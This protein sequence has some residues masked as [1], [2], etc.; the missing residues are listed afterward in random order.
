MG[1]IRTICETLLPSNNSNAHGKNDEKSFTYLS[2]AA[3]SNNKK[4]TKTNVHSLKKK[5][6]YTIT[7]EYSYLLVA[8][9]AG[10]RRGGKGSKGAADFWEG[11][12]V[13]HACFFP[14]PFPSTPATQANLLEV[15]QNKNYYYCKPTLTLKLRLTN[16][17]Y[18]TSGNHFGIHFCKQHRWTDQKN[19][20]LN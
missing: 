20:L 12:M 19:N 7:P 9:V 8:H 6:L 18:I 3:I 17:Y 11:R 14:F 15:H 10:R 16:K 13:S 1:A 4:G 2:L 5:N